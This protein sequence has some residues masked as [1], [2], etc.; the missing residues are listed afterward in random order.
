MGRM[1]L[2]GIEANSSGIKVLLSAFRIFPSILK[3]I[4]VEKGIIEPGEDDA[5][6]LTRDRW[7]PLESWLAVHDVILKEIGP[8]ALLS[9]GERLV[10]ENPN[11]PKGIKDVPSALYALDIAFHRS[12]RKLGRMMYDPATGNMLEGIGHYRSRV[13]PGEEKA[14]VTC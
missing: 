2:A 7:F 5:R 3:R 14:E 12:H 11:F 8:T 13:I 10:E 6:A 1:S 4:L 9:L